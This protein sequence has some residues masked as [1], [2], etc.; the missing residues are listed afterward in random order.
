MLDGLLDAAASGSA[1]WR[2]RARGSAA[3]LIALAVEASAAAVPSRSPAVG[4]GRRRHRLRADA[5]GA[6]FAVV[7][8]AVLLV[9]LIYEVLAGIARRACPPSSC[10]WPPG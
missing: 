6:V 4:T 5:L 1:G 7:S 8:A 3:G 9:A 10:F 2:S